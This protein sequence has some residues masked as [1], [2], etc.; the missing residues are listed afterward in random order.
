MKAISSQGLLIRM[1][2]IMRILMMT[3]LGVS[4]AILSAH[5]KPDTSLA[6]I[7]AVPPHMD[8]APKNWLKQLIVR[9]AEKSANVTPSV[10][11]AVARIESSFRPRVVSSAGA[12]GVMQIMPRTGRDLF[13]LSQAELFDPATNIRAG[14]T[15]L[16][17]LI[18]RYDGRIDLA[19]SHYNGGSRVASGPQPKIIPATRGY[20]LKV[21]AAAR[22]YQA[23]GVDTADETASDVGITMAGYTSSTLPLTSGASTAAVPAP[24][25]SF[26]P[27]AGKPVWQ[28]YLNEADFWVAAAMATRDAGALPEMQINGEGRYAR[29]L[30]KR[31]QDNRQAFRHWLKASR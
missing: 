28:Q 12:I 6:S 19:L 5:A 24:T 22:A 10:A 31:L 23:Q 9:E 26:A 15:F 2:I 21:L 8:T 4:A 18:E 13:G 25:G 20:V 11:L 30:V 1:L 29:A 3:G 7:H 16:D 17:Q 27:V 14:V